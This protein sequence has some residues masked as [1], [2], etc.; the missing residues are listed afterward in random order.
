MRPTTEPL[1]TC[2]S[3]EFR[4]T[5]G[6]CI[7]IRFK[8]NKEDNCGDES[9]EMGCPCRNHELTCDNGNCVDK[10][11]RCDGEDDCGDMTDERNCRPLTTPGLSNAT[12]P[13][14]ERQGQ[15]ILFY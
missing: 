9:D 13:T 5:S 10:L 12:R 7:D 4:C 11:W 6:K 8:C 15:S 3:N 1:R 14:V 2:H